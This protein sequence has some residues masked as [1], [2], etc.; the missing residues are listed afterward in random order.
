MN[1]SI[2]VAIPPKV[3]TWVYLVFALVGV[4]FGATQVGYATANLAV[5]TWLNVAVAVY[6]FL[7]GAVG[8]TAATHTPAAKNEVQG[9]VD[10]VHELGAVG[11][12][13]MIGVLLVA[14][15]ILGL[16]G[17]VNLGLTVCVIL[18]IIGVVLMV[19]DHRGTLRR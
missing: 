14:V 5:P 16:L 17:V 7:G 3:R 19:L 12:L 8:L 1:N 11:V 10:N 2:L 9:D 13:F 15:A 4:A 18:A 6:T